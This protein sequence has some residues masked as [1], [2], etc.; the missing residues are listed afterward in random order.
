VKKTTRVPFCVRADTNRGVRKNGRREWYGK[1]GRLYRTVTERQYR[2]QERNT[3]GGDIDLS[4]ELPCAMSLA[5]LC[6]SDFT[7]LLSRQQ[8]IAI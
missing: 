7:I 8:R 3:I 2:S 1:E 6:S 4:W 5:V